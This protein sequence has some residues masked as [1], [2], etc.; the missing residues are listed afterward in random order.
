MLY[1]KFKAITTPFRQPFRTSHGLKTEQPALLVAL[2]FSGITGFGEAPAIHY[3]GVDT[4]SMLAKL[5]DKK[6]LIERY[7]FTEPERFWH[8]CH[9][10][11][12]EDAFLVCALDMAYWDLYAKFKKTSF[13]Q[14][15][16]LPAAKET[17][18]DYTIGLDD[19][20]KMLEKMSAQPWP[21]Y[22]I[23]VSEPSHLEILKRIR[24]STSS[25]IR[26]DANAGWTPEHAFQMLPELEKLQIELIEQPLAST[27]HDAMRAL[28]SISK[29]PLIADESCVS[30]KDVA[31]LTDQFH[32]I[33]IKLTKCGGIT[34]A[35]RMIQ[36]A[37]QRGLQVMLGCMNETEIG[38]YPMVHL[39]SSVDYVDLD[40]PLLLDV[41][42]PAFFGYDHGKIFLKQH[43]AFAESR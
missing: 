40:G 2:S 35:L 3:Y 29:I 37:R 32:G 10:L 42:D 23:K 21:I 39:A 16:N 18:T 1:L 34:P 28:K 8:Y 14:L 38:T 30:E 13:R 6:E 7:A 27:E 20:E 26:I 25:V 31:M 41:P 9:H 33:N 15:W 12:P 22:K 4:E 5:N 24:Q 19:P 11:F 36:E 17:L 43:P